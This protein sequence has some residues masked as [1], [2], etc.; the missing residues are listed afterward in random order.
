MGCSCYV[1]HSATANTTLILS[2]CSL[3]VV[4]VVFS[5]SSFLLVS[6]N[7]FLSFSCSLHSPCPGIMAQH[8]KTRFFYMIIFHGR[9]REKGEPSRVQ[10][11][12][13][14][15]LYR[16]WILPSPSFA[17]TIFILLT[18]LVG[19]TVF[20]YFSPSLFRC[21]PSSRS[22]WAICISIMLRDS[23]RCL[24]HPNNNTQKN[25]VSFVTV[26]FSKLFVSILENF[27]MP[28]LCCHNVDDDDGVCHLL[29]RTTFTIFQ[30]LQDSIQD[31]YVVC[32]CARAILI[33]STHILWNAFL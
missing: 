6:L 26:F 14:N 10:L 19:R 30:S 16:L 17:W 1:H 12:T 18:K 3:S 9:K 32:V 20:L 8:P 23:T 28:L 13:I 33:Y 11:P 25:P 21:V 15:A 2:T 7:R 22:S 4:V 29:P 5:F 27:M 31:M 24:F